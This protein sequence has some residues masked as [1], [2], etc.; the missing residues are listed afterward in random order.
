ML[1]LLL[2][3]IVSL[4]LIAADVAYGY[5]PS[6]YGDRSIDDSIGIKAG[7][8]AVH[9]SYRRRPLYYR[10][11]VDPGAY[12]VRVFYPTVD[13]KDEP[14][15]AWSVPG[16]D[17]QLQLATSAP[18][19]RRNKAPFATVACS[20]QQATVDG[21]TLRIDFSRIAYRSK[22]QIS[23]I[24]V[25]GSGAFVCRINCGGE[26]VTDADGNVWQA[27]QAWPLPQARVQVAGDLATGEWVDIATPVLQ[28]LY[29]LGLEPT[30]KYDGTY[31][32]RFNGV[33]CDR[34]GRTYFNF[35][36]LGL[37]LYEGPGGVLYR[38]DDGAYASV[39]KGEQTNPY[40]PGF[41]LFSS[42]GFLNQEVYQCFSPD[43][44]SFVPFEGN[45]DRGSVDWTQ[46]PPQVIY[47]DFRH[48]SRTTLSTDGGA[49]FHD[50]SD[51]GKKLNVGMVAAL[52]EGV[53]IRSLTKPRAEHP[54]EGIYR[55]TDL[56]QTWSKVRDG[57]ID[58]AQC[59]PVAVYRERVYLST[60]EGVLKSSDRGETWTLVD[61]SPV[62]VVN[63]LIGADD[64]HLLAFNEE[65]GFASS[66]RGE[67]WNKVLPPPP[68]KVDPLDKKQK[69][70]QS[71][72]YYDFAWDVAQDVIW[73]YAP[74]AVYRYQR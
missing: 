23:G 43:G 58:G 47:A 26:Q 8:E 40:G 54:D 63:P 48:S 14:T 29:D 55:S 59:T 66:D 16:S 53:L 62:F 73:A 50:V 5:Y 64:S 10:L 22:W 57:D 31:T 1:K 12:Q 9:R 13:G 20:E 37:W 69:W 41:C 67:T 51:E 74:D 32:R 44:V 35:A 6:W 3:T 7:N 45:R 39:M 52:G 17:K 19:T 34:S 56:G 36:G 68:S 49:S 65:G 18:D 28:Q 72:G 38:V 27:D 30:P 60:P 61:G 4:P 46:S 25:I 11:Q 21:D 24:E 15:I 71:H 2:L 42:H 33:I 70:L